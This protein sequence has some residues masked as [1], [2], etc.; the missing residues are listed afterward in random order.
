MSADL[1]VPGVL[2]PLLAAEPILEYPIRTE[3]FPTPEESVEY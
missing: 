1:I 2:G 3:A